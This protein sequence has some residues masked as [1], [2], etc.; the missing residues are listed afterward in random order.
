MI[1]YRKFRPTSF[2]R[3]GLLGEY[4]GISD[5][6]VLLA[7]NRDSSIL[8]ESNFNIALDMLGGESENVQVHRFGH[9]ASGWFELI[10]I[11]PNSPEWN[12]AEKIETKIEEYPILDEN[13]YTERQVEAAINYWHCCGRRE[14]IEI[15]N[16]FGVSI[17]ASRR[18]DIPDD[19]S[20]EL[21]TYLAG[22]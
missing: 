20:G 14:R 2:D 10:L 9:W 21:F 3:K 11:A 6:G 13:D 8:Q 5:Y 4:H 17:Y 7:R 18:D 1:R 22:E 12:L 19:Y 16:K 15:C